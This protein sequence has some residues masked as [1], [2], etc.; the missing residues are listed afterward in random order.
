MADDDSSHQTPQL[1]LFTPLGDDVLLL[2]S[3]EGSEQLSRLFKFTLQLYCP[4]KKKDQVKFE[5]LLGKEFTIECDVYSREK[6]KRTDESRYFSGICFEFSEGLRDYDFTFYTAEIVP[7]VQLL[8]LQSDVRMF[9]QKN[10]PDILKEVLPKAGVEYQLTG[11]YDKREY[12]VQYRETNWDFACR[13]MEEEG[14]FFFFKYAKS[15]H[16]MVIADS[17]LKHPKVQEPD[18]VGHDPT[19]G[20]NRRLAFIST[21]AKA[22]R[23]KSTKHT[24]RDYHFQLPNSNL[25]STKTTPDSANVGK[26]DHKL[27]VATDELEIYDYPG[28]YA[29]RVDGVNKSG[30]DQSS[31][32]QTVHSNS[33]RTAK[34]RNEEETM[35]AVLINA[36]SNCLNFVSGHKF[37]VEQ[38]EASKDFKGDGDY[39]LTEVKHHAEVAVGYRSGEAEKFAYSNTFACTPLQINY[40]APRVTKKP[41]VMGIQSA[42]VVG[43]E[44][45]EIVTDKYGRVKVQFHWDRKG[46]NDANSS[47]WLRVATAWA[48]K[49]WGMIHIPRIG[50]EV[51][52]DFIEGD[53]DAP[54]IIGSVYNPN[55]MPPYT[56]PDNKT[57]SGIKTRSSKGGSPDNFNEIRFEDKKGS[58]ELYIHAEKDKNIVV[59]HDKTEKIGHDQ[60]TTVSNNDTEMVMNQQSITIGTSQDEKV[61][62]ERTTMVGASD[63]LTVG[64]E[65]SVTTGAADSLTAGAEIGLTAGAAMTLSA[66]AEI[67]VTAGGAIAITASAAITITASATITIMAPAVIICGRPVAPTPGVPI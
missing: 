40:R 42:T 11:T 26:V 61:G 2:K 30:G 52:V 16:T 18:T 4:N 8:T 20:G 24:Y 22:Q 56:L 7:K 10:V 13:L 44:G 47:C 39:V 48:G 17:A 43:P 41:T 14:I 6:E 34:L 35:P 29:R 54:I 66:G 55:T 28:G 57:Q 53:P 63:S 5:K 33:Q 37:S 3:F 15:S 67:S 60:T 64:A 62:T 46:Q 51:I 23:L 25:E 45:E 65:R 31:E 38:T 27:K 32:L 9:Q 19:E 36:Q 12:C 21:W 59:E 50:Q 1:R 58:E 49:Q